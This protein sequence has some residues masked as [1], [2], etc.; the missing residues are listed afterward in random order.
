MGQISLR[1]ELPSRFLERRPEAVLLLP[2]RAGEAKKALILLH[3]ATEGPEAILDN[4]PVERLTEELGLAVLLP[5]LDNSFGLD[6]GEGL[7]Y[8][9][10]LLLELLP[11]VRELCPAFGVRERCALGGI[12]MGGFAALSIALSHPGDF[13]GVFSVSGALNP[14]R[15]SQFCR[16]GQIT[17]PP[18]FSAFPSRPEAQLPAILEAVPQSDRM[19]LF[20]AWGEED[21]FSRDNE[22]FAEKAAAMGY[23]IRTEHGPGLHD[24]SYWRQ[25][26]PRALRWASGET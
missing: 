21:W 15:S 13:G 18:G 2:E 17:V 1:L 11:K 12:S 23:P 25:T 22:S 24:W 3:G 14:K 16:I 9:S 8:R 7:D 5:A 20:L 26:L 4:C 10:W 6:W 19:P